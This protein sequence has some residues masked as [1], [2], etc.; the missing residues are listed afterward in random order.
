MT[1]SDGL[2]RLRQGNY[3]IIYGIENDILVIR[4]VK[5]AHK[6]GAYR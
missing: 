1:D 3:Q 2:Y 5:I 4:V 6:K